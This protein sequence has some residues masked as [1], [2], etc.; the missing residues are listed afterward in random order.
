[1]FNFKTSERLLL[2]AFG[3]RGMDNL[4]ELLND[5]RVLPFL[6]GLSRLK[7]P[8]DARHSSVRGA[9]EARDGEPGMRSVI[10]TSPRWWNIGFGSEV[11]AWGI[12]YAFRE[13]GQHRVSLTVFGINTRATDLYRRMAFK[14]EGVKR[15]VNWNHGEWEDII[16]M[17]ILDEEWRRDGKRRKNSRVGVPQMAMRAPLRTRTIS[18]EKTPQREF[19]LMPVSSVLDLKVGETRFLRSAENVFL[20]PYEETARRYNAHS[21]RSRPRIPCMEELKLR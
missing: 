11:T 12:D 7:G 10:R 16:C 14:Q 4:M 13:L 5:K 8:R 17:A 18:K 6:D 2:R 20:T 15:K 9:R 3:K 1:M 19:V 21:L